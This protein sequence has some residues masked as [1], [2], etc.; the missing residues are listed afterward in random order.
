[1][2]LGFGASDVC[3]GVRCAGLMRSMCACRSRGYRRGRLCM[4]MRM[5]LDMGAERRYMR[6]GLGAVLRFW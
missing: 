4:R 6:A 2:D 1:M 3:V 5:C